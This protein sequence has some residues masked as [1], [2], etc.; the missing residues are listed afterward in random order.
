MYHVS[1]LS[2]VPIAT[3]VDLLEGS[4]QQIVCS[5]VASQTMF[6]ASEMPPDFV[7]VRKASVQTEDVT[8]KKVGLKAHV[9]AFFAL[10]SRFVLRTC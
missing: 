10:S 2:F 9:P 5:V 1:V 4:P 6:V 7:S 3:D 8:Q